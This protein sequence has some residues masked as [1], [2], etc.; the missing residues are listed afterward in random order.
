ME[1]R[2]KQLN[3]ALAINSAINKGTEITLIIALN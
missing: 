1:L 3:G 2:A